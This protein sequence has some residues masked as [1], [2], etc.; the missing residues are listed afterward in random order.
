VEIYKIMKLDHMEFNSLLLGLVN[1]N[2]ISKLTTLLIFSMISMLYLVYALKIDHSIVLIL[3]L[4][5]ENLILNVI[6]LI[7]IPMFVPIRINHYH[8]K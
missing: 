7:M 5:L 6:F 1:I 3:K 2:L 4:V 8:A